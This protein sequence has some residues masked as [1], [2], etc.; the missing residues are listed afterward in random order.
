MASV[1]V[2]CTLLHAAL[3]PPHAQGKDSSRGTSGADERA[4][5]AHL[6]GEVAG[7]QRIER[8]REQFRHGAHRAYAQTPDWCD[9]GADLT[10]RLSPTS[11]CC[12]EGRRCA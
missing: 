2:V 12:P 9:A 3:G 5:V 11:L 1:P 10:L 4:L 7:G 8:N 6:E